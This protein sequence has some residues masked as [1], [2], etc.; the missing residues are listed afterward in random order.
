MQWS[1]KG[2]RHSSECNATIRARRPAGKRSS[3][4]ES[5]ELCEDHRAFGGL[6]PCSVTVRETFVLGVASEPGDRTR[7]RTSETVEAEWTVS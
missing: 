4:C 6:L 1:D 3:R 7:E 5:I 2:L